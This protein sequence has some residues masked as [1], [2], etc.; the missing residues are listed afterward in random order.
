[1]SQPLI[2]ITTSRGSPGPG[3]VIR[4]NETYVNAILRAGG[5]PVLIP[6]SIPGEDCGRLL[7]RL[8]GLL[9]SGGGD[10]DPEIFDGTP[11]V[12]VYG[13]VP[14]RDVLEINLVKIAVN[15]GLPVLGICRGIQIF[16]VALGGTLFT[17]ISDQLPQ[18]LKHDYDD[19]AF[20]AHRVQVDCGSRLAHI[21]KAAEVDTNSLHHQGIQRLAPALTPAATTSDSLIEAVEMTGH[22][23]CLGVQWHPEGM[24]DSPQMQALFRAF[25]EAAEKN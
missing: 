23:F 9:L 1:M 11:H 3:S 6:P 8:D 13:I 18:A 7:D 2:G 24:P 5:V 19:Y 17:H 20:I 22:P 12:K 14:D 21:L 15:L 10:I 4:L 16:N 25:V